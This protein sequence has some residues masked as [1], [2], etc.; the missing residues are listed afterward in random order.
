MLRMYVT[1]AH[2]RAM[3]A[4]VVGILGF[5]DVP[6]VYM[7]NRW[8]RTQHPEPV[9]G[10]G[11]ESGLDPRM[12]MGVLAVFT[13]LVLFSIV[14]MRQRYRLESMQAEIIEIERAVQA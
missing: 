7:A 4:A 14:L 10:G 13:G 2:R 8:W 6:I 12:W 3:L 9:I 11:D 1:E 5:V